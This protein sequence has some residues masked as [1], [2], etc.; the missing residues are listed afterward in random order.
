MIIQQ[1]GVR[2]SVIHCDACGESL[3]DSMI[4]HKDTCTAMDH[5]WHRR[6]ESALQHLDE[7]TN[8]IDLLHLRI[9]SL[10]QELAEKRE[11]KT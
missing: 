6:W 5:Y 1:F 9:H 3:A 11:G 10:E 8:L 4:R 2:D 7:M